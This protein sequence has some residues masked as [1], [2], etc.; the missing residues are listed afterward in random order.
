MRTR[1]RADGDEGGEEISP[2]LGSAVCAFISFP[3]RRGRGCVSDLPASPHRT[4]FCADSL[5]TLSLASFGT[6]KPSPSLS[7]A[8]TG[9]KPLDWPGGVVTSLGPPFTESGKSDWPSDGHPTRCTPIG[10]GPPRG[11]SPNSAFFQRTA[12]PTGS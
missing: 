1:T 11:S 12:P 8:K 9:G 7:L 2:S 4:A 3:C 6:Q 5:V 10:R